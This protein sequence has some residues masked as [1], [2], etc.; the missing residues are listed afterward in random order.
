MQNSFRIRTEIGQDR[1]VNFQLDQNIE[2][3][4]I[5]SFKIRQSDVYTLDCAN[6]GVV[7][8][9]VTANNGFGIPNA[10]V[11]IFIPLSE[12]DENNELITSIYPYKT[13]NE[14][15]EDG[16][17]YNLLP[18]KPSYPGHIAT[19]TFPSLND[20][21]FD[22]QA[23]EVYEKYYKYTV[24]TNSSGDYMIFGIPVGSY[25]ILMDLDLSDMGEYSL[26]PQDLIRMGMATEGQFDNNQYQK[27]TDLNSLP[28]IVSISKGLNISPLW[29]NI[30]TCDSSI[31]R[32]DFDLRDDVNIDIQPTAIFMGSIFSTA[33]SKRIRS[34]CKPKDDFGNLCGLE[35]GPGE[36][37][38]IR[39]SFNKDDKGLP[40][41]ETF[42]VGK[43]IDENGAWVV[44][45]PMNLEY[46]ITNENGDKI[47]TNDPTIGIP[48]KAKYR[49]K[50]KW[51]QSSKISEQTKRAYFLVPNIREYGWDT[52]GVVDPFD[53]TTQNKLDLAKSYYFGLDWD[54]YANVDAAIKCEDTF[55]EFKSNKVYTVSSLIDQY[56][57][58]SNKGSFIGI[59]EIADTSCDSTTNKYPVND[60]VRNFD[61]LYFVV[62]ILLLLFSNTGRVLVI[63]Y[64]FVKFIWNLFAVPLVYAVSIALPIVTAFLFLQAA[65]SFPSV[66]LILGFAA[67]GA[68]ATKATIE[69]FKIFKDVKNFRFQELNLPMITYPD[70]ELCDCSGGD[71]ERSDGGIPTGGLISQLANPALYKEG[72]TAKVETLIKGDKTINKN[73][74]RV[75]E[76]LLDSDNMVS[77]A[78]EAYIGQIYDANKPNRFRALF[79]NI[80]LMPS[81]RAQVAAASLGLSPAERINKFNHRENYFKGNTR[82]GVTFASKFNLNQHNDNVLIVITSENRESGTLLTFLNFDKSKDINYISGYIA[83]T[84]ISAETK[85]QTINVSYAN[86]S[87]PKSSLT[88]EY[89]L[90]YG[91]D[92][93]KYLFPADI[94]FYQV[95]TGMTISEFKNKNKNK[96]ENPGNDVSF[97]WECLK[98]RSTQLFIDHAEGKDPNTFYWENHIFSEVA[99]GDDGVI[100]YFND[101]ENQ[102]VLILQRGVDPY[103]PLYEN[104]YSLGNIFGFSDIDAIKITTNARLNIP[105]Q[106]TQNYSIQ[107]ISNANEVL[108]DS[109][110]LKPI[111]T[112]IGFGPNQAYAFNT[113]ANGYYSNSIM[114][115]DSPTT[116]FMFFNFSG[117]LRGLQVGSNNL[118]RRGNILKIDGD[119]IR[120]L[121][122]Y[123]LSDNLL[124]SSTYYVSNGMILDGK[125]SNFLKRLLRGEEVYSNTYITQTSF[126]ENITNDNK[127]Y[128]NNKTI[129]RTDRL[130]TSDYLDGASWSSTTVN[131]FYINKGQAAALQQNLGFATYEIVGS[132]QFADNP[133]PSSDTGY[134][135]QDFSGYTVSENLLTTLNSCNNMVSLSCYTGKGVDFKVDETCS[136]KDSVENGCYTFAKRTLLDIPK[137]LRTYTE[138]INRFRFFYALCRGVV[139]EVFVNNWVN[140]SLFAFPI[141]TKIKYDNN[142]QAILD[143]ESYCNDL[144][145]FDKSTSNFYYR[146][147][148][149]NRSKD[150]FV[151]RKVKK[152]EENK[153]NLL[154]PTTIMDLGY[155]NSLYGFNSDNFEYYSFVMN[156]LEPTS[157]GD[158]SDILNLFAISRITNGNFIKNLKNINDLFSRD[159]KKTD[160]D[161]SQLLSINS[162]F[163]VDKFSTEFYSMTN[164]ANSEISI[165]YDKKD[166][167][168]IGI[169]YSSSQDDLQLKD[170]LTPGRVNFRTQTN[171]LKPKYF[172]IKSQKVPFYQWAISGSTAFF[173]DETNTWYTATIISD[174]YQNL[175]R[176]KPDLASIKNS[177]NPKNT[178]KYFYNDESLLSYNNDRG[179]LYNSKNQATKYNNRKNIFAVGAPFYFYF[180][181]KKGA[182]ALD[183]FKTKYLNE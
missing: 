61:F 123:D 67:L 41:L 44:E 46:V 98:P 182:S 21:M 53:S 49:F 155:K 18:Y 39:Q 74:T 16:Y 166:K 178:E 56:R 136:D 85:N 116:G 75:D 153:K 89:K 73:Q 45:L 30:E 33:S 80:Y 23:S 103:S 57:G 117:N 160:G 83:T 179:Y 84:K 126:S 112:S 111:N 152:F 96:S 66:G 28:Q 35:S 52:N 183:I 17:R 158:N 141:Q 92:I 106:P 161:Y 24:K 143:E 40:V 27:S 14:K 102:Y 145:Y 114:S 172:G 138:W 127:L 148:P 107:E 128:V 63:V 72:I 137:D 43:V 176:I 32:V 100:N 94:E 81:T 139:S 135:P 59:K 8:G 29:G 65:T 147:S 121:N 101:F 180:G 48:T 70:C 2:F 173:G 115:D 118:F 140:G 34:N 60:G 142:N 124:G 168:I 171:E 20:V 50:V 162:E 26:T 133:I 6:Y 177:F 125:K 47:I 54:G 58:G 109:Y 71:M 86:P 169:F 90:P 13:I 22:G 77:L 150:S 76:M 163:G 3:L 122:G 95:L 25:T 146:S 175:D 170:Y 113:D 154:F 4:E 159:Y 97:M 42:R 12:E 36:I 110:F 120:I 31:N 1:V 82:I 104:T 68:L 9:R 108:F 167:P 11:S 19:G 91:V 15:N 131:G 156:N 79:S 7:A 181:I 129:F 5:L 38:A 165:Q 132:E 130:P 151:G 88:K 119:Y 99:S 174:E 144:I 87:N 78:T 164:S 157:Y 51:E 62:S 55:Y 149:Y 93:D 64:H 10:R 37:L 105:I 69:W 134:S